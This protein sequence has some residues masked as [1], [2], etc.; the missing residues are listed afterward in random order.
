ME[1]RATQPSELEA[2]R[3]LLVAAGW[4][5]GV[6]NAAEFRELVSRSQLTLVAIEGVEV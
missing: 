4:D 5:R 2:A 3:Q 1:V 6:S